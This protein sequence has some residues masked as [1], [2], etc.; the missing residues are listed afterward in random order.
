[1][2][3]QL[4]QKSSSAIVPISQLPAVVLGGENDVER[5]GVGNVEERELAE[6]KLSFPAA[7]WEKDIIEWE[8]HEGEKLIYSRKRLE[9]CMDFS[10]QCFLGQKILDS[11]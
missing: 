6:V 7:Q 2:P 9:V 5:V 1:M 3:A 8:M 4:K 11:T 10:K